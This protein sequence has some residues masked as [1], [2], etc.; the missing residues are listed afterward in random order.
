[1][2]P[3][4]T[5]AEQGSPARGQAGQLLAPLR[6]DESDTLLP[7]LIYTLQP[8]L[9]GGPRL[10][11]IHD[12]KTGERRVMLS[13]PDEVPFAFEAIRL[14]PAWP[15][16]VRREPP[17]AAFA[18]TLDRWTNDPAAL[19]A[20]LLTPA[21]VTERFLKA[22]SVPP[23]QE[24]VCLHVSGTLTLTWPADLPRTGPA[25]EQAVRQ[26]VAA[27]RSLTWNEVEEHA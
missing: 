6:C 11:L 10:H 26:T 21:D 15:E 19:L 12:R 13:D 4:R 14:D 25:W 3:N 23:V 17:L 24:T 8:D 16:A 2:T 5:P 18:A 9:P 20:V 7:V 27:T 22:I 1:M